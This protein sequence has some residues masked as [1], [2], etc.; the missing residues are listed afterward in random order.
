MSTN[1]PFCGVGK[2]PKGRKPG[3]MKECAELKQVRKFE[4]TRKKGNIK[5]TRDQ[6]IIQIAGAKGSINR[7]KGRK[8]TLEKKQARKDLTAD[9]KKSLKEYTSELKKAENVLE[10]ASAKL[11]KVLQANQAAKVKEA[12]KSVVKKK[13]VKK[14]AGRPGTKR[15]VKKK[16]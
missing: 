16:V 2:A 9:E 13:P 11:K 8:E 3:N 4:A 1:K 6:L 15:K 10:K 12:K 14:M 5:E 7:F